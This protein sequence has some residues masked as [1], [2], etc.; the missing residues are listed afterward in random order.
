MTEFDLVSAPFYFCDLKSGDYNCPKKDE[1]KRYLMIKDL[2]YAEYGKY[3]FARMY[4]ICSKQNYRMFM[5]TYPGEFD[6]E[7]ENNIGTQKTD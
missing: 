4:N 7:G 6:K 2:D 1:C 3:S 5:K